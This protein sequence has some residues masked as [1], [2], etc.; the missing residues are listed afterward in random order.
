MGVIFIDLPEVRLFYTDRGSGPLL[1]FVHGWMCDSHDWSW[2]LPAF[3]D[4]RAIAVDLRGH[5][6]SSV[7]DDG[8]TTKRFAADLVALLDAVDAAPV[9]VIGHSLGGAVVTALAVEHPDR[10]RGCV[11]V[12]PALGLPAD[13]GSA[14]SSTAMGFDGPEASERL[15]AIMA[16]MSN[17]RTPRH[18]ARAARHGLSAERRPPEL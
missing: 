18:L 14:L 1:L 7:P 12:D 9:V 6:R 15:G 10:V 11:T 16:G 5:G 17:D 13:M 4:Y 3:E 8:Y 2:Q